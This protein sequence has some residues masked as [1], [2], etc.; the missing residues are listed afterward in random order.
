MIANITTGSFL[1]PLFDYNQKKVKEGV[2]KTLLVG[3]VF[4]QSEQ[5]AQNLML[6]IASQSKR[7]DKFFHASLNFPVDDKVALS[8]TL[9]KQ[10]SKDYMAGMG[11]PEDHPI[12]IYR[13]E[14]TEHPHLH[15]VTSKILANG[16]PLPDS[17]Y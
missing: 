6:S 1:K 16:R 5:T 14:D 7:K 4:D 10:I 15:I 11:F 9:M 2:A 13:H 12:V 3:N 17:H 8:D